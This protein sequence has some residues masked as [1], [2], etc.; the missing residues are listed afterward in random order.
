[1]SHARAATLTFFVRS[2]VYLSVNLFEKPV[3]N[4]VR[5]FSCF[6]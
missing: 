6:L 2:E 5:L 1:M 4:A 3:H